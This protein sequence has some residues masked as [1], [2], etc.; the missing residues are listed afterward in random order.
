MKMKI[1]LSIYLS[2]ISIVS[3]SQNEEK[4]Y[5]DS[6]W[7]TLKSNSKCKYYRVIEYSDSGKIL[8][9]IKDYYCK[10]NEL[11]AEF[12]SDKVEIKKIKYGSSIKEMGMY[13][14]KAIIHSENGE[15]QTNYFSKGI[16][17]N[18]IKPGQLNLIDVTDKFDKSIV[19]EN[20]TIRNKIIAKY[21]RELHKYSEELKDKN[22][23]KEQLCKDALDKIKKDNQLSSKVLVYPFQNYPEDVVNNFFNAF[24]YD[25]YSSFPKLIDP[26]GKTDKDTQEMLTLIYYLESVVP[27]KMREKMIGT[28]KNLNPTIIDSK[29]EGNKAV[30]EI[31]I[32]NKKTNIKMYLIQRHGYWFF[33]NANYL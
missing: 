26:Y 24:Q 28:F 29:T 22:P 25:N 21:T 7:K 20:L 6:N 10:N 17:T 16:L 8:M 9:P 33:S 14:G 5:F 2:I 13:T 27:E 31:N 15:K 30:L 11:Q 3:Y 4:I 12:Y 23:E 1:Y 19:E 18:T 32:E